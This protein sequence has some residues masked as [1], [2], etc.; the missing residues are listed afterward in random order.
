MPIALLGVALVVVLDFGGP[1]AVDFTDAPRVTFTTAS[2]VVEAPAPA[3][4]A[5]VPTSWSRVDSRGATWTH[6]DRAVLDAHVDRV[7]WGYMQ[8]APPLYYTPAG[9]TYTVGAACAR[10]SCAPAP[11]RAGFRLFRRR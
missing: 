10:G 8:P 2:R 11:A 1:P 4:P 5:P 3:P 7:E 9:T 6:P